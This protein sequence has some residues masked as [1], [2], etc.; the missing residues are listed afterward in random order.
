MYKIQGVS[1]QDDRIAYYIYNGSTWKFLTSYKH[2]PVTKI[3]YLKG[4]VLEPNIET[5]IPEHV[6]KIL[7]S[8]CTPK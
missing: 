4:I 8:Y 5:E 1:S 7:I 3:L 2:K 6:Y